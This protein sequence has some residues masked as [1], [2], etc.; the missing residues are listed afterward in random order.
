MRSRSFG[1]GGDSYI[2]MDNKGN[3]SFGP[4]RAVPL[5]VAAEKN[6]DLVEEI[7]TLSLCSDYHFVERQEM[8]CLSLFKVANIGNVILENE[9]K[10]IITLLKEKSH[11]V[12]Y[13]SNHLNKDIDS[14]K[15]KRLL[16]LDIVQLISLTPTDILHAT[17]EYT[18]YDRKISQIAVERLAKRRRMQESEFVKY[19]ENAFVEQIC[20]ALIESL[21]AGKGVKEENI[22]DEVVRCIFDKRNEKNRF[23]D[24]SLKLNV[25]IVGIGAPAKIW[26]GKV[27]EKLH[28][29]VIVPENSE[30]A[31]A[32]GTVSGNI[33]ESLEALIRYDSHMKK[34]IAH[35]PNRRL[36]FEKL[37]EAIE[38]AEKELMMCGKEFAEKLGVKKYHACIYKDKVETEGRNNLQDNFVELRMKLAISADVKN[39]N[40]KKYRP[41]NQKE[42]NNELQNRKV[43]EII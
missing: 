29:C 25:P 17:G 1:L 26:F 39:I 23:A 32:V 6:P 18:Q 4:E 34:Y 21:L 41:L 36:V 33:R 27:A 15:I 19:A 43:K 40:H 20:A 2:R 30:V 3:L 5:C 12:L 24:F 22:S 10:E 13:I 31:N 8:D 37:D 7:K 9:E 11:S 28:C 14:I 42:E 38:S 35:L 16:A